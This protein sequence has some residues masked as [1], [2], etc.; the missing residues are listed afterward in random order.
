MNDSNTPNQEPVAKPKKVLSKNRKARQV[1][2]PIA[3]ILLVAIPAGTLYYW[4]R[5]VATD[6]RSQLAKTQT[7]LSTASSKNTT[8]NTQLTAQKATSKKLQDQL[9]AIAANASI[10]QTSLNLVVNR[11]SR[12]CDLEFNSCRN[13]YVA[14]NV[15]LTNNTS[16]AINV[17]SSGFKLKD[18]N[19][20]SFTG[21]TGSYAQSRLG[22]GYPDLVDQVLQ[23][24]EKVTGAI[25][26]TVA[27][28][29]ITSYTLVNGT[30]EYPV[31]ATAWT[32]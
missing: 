5:G 12:Y 15:T 17:V 9:A 28:H 6:L 30:H 1:L 27:D 11:A 3:A 32:H 18:A 7:R 20:S 8:L 24:G 4:Q 16:T 23:P 22:S 2:T 19:S 14:V 10:T 25:S 21:G 13:N 31:S 26:F 29:D